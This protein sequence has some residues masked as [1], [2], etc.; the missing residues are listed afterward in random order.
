MVSMALMP[1]SPLLGTSGERN[2]ELSSM[3]PDSVAEQV[4][5]VFGK[6]H[7]PGCPAVHPT[8]SVSAGSLVWT[9]H[10][11][12][13]NAFEVGDGSS[14]GIAHAGVSLGGA[15][16]GG[17]ARVR[18]RPIRAVSLFMRWAM[19]GISSICSC[20][21]VEFV[22]CE[23]EIAP[24]V[25]GSVPPQGDK[26]RWKSRGGACSVCGFHQGRNGATAATGA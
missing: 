22:P 10:R 16:A 20:G 19:M 11:M 25:L 15:G 3:V 5:V 13:R 6:G 24:A 2:T 17:V 18:K 23:L 14:R 7:C 8:D 21:G 1:A 4:A 9:E 26:A 12:S